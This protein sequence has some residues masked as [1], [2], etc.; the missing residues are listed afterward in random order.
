MNSIKIDPGLTEINLKV[1]LFE[2][3]GYQV[4]YSPGLNLAGQGDSEEEAIE[5]LKFTVKKPL[6]GA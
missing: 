5:D 3:F 6:S 4:A 1:E 2:E